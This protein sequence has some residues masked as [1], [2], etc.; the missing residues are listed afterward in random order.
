MTIT[1]EEKIWIVAEAIANAYEITPSG[2]VILIHPDTL[3]E[4]VDKI[5]LEQ[6]LEKFVNDHQIIKIVSHPNDLILSNHGVCFGIKI[7]DQLKFR[8]FLN[9]AHSKH[10]GAIDRLAGDNFFAICDVAMDI[11][12]ELQLALNEK[13]SIPIVPS[14]IKFERLCPAKSVGLLDRYGDFRMKALMYMKEREYILDFK[15]QEDMY[16]NR[17]DKEV[18]VWVDRFNFEKFYQKLGVAYEVRVVEPAK[19]QKK[20]QAVPSMPTSTKI[21]ITA[22]PELLVRNAR[23]NINTTGLYITKENDDFSYKGHY[24][25]LSKKS[26]YYKV[27]C[28]LYAKL[29]NGGEVPYKDLVVEI[30]S[31]LLWKTQNKTDDE[32]RKFIQRNLTDKS[33]GFMRYAGIPET[34][35]NGK[36]LIEVV[37]GT[38]IVFN[39]KAG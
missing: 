31:R 5:E 26:D 15:V 33:N 16:V 17:W 39:N 4:K 25:N 3:S 38:G 24:L 29:P 21:E 13:I 2:K 19:K 7:P 10:F 34:E 11:C 37:R 18:D 6:I 35:D 9:F 8:E 23:D 36:P 27:F 30:K 20:G 22:M 12:A 32:M 1:P 14:I 28:A